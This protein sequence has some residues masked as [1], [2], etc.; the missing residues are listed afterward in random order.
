MYNYS[1]IKV[2]HLEVTSKCQASCPMCARNL[3]GGIQNPFLITDEIKLK[4]FK[5]W[6]PEKFLKQLTRL[7]MCGNFGDPIIAEDTLEIFKYI[8]SVNDNIS[9]SMN[10]NGSAR[11][12][13]W[14]KEL[15][16]TKVY[17]R[18]GIDGLQ[19]T[20]ILYRINTDFNKI[21]DNA[22]S[23]INA[24]GIAVWDMLVFEHNKHQVDQCKEISKNL[25]FVNFVTKNTSRFKENKLTVLDNLGKTRHTLYPSR[26][27][28]DIKKKVLETQEVNNT[29]IFCKVKNESS[30][31]ISAN[32]NVFP[33]CWLDFYSI[34]PINQNRID[35]MDNIGIFLNLKKFTLNEIFN[36]G[37]FE[38]IQNTWDIN[39]LKEC[40]KQCGL[41][42]KFNEQ[43][44]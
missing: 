11:P 16:N 18:F 10:T 4:D 39:P 26:K 34:P 6:F 23:F 29:K 7:Y 14:W 32:G 5:E 13:K 28:L 38:K 41:V 17:V 3:Q 44:S 8:R 31:Y 19:D 22:Q 42:D 24:G 40:S 12:S 15:A 36:S 25:G 2:I 43:F 30:L 33:C 27:S 20:H 37:Y 21:L 35:Y 1:D 9:L